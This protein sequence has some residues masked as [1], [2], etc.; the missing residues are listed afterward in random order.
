MLP[1]GGESTEQQRTG[2]S[3][4][5]G[6]FHLRNLLRRFGRGRAHARGRAG[7]PL[8]SIVLAR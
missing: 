6:A 4:A 7:L 3:P 5:P 8:R 2:K 1:P